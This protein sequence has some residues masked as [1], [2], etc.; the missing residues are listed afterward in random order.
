MS[1]IVF[2]SI[3]AYGHT[4]PT[5]EVVRQLVR[6]GHRVRYYS[7]EEFRAKLEGAGAEFVPC[8]TFLPPAPRDLGRRMGHDF[9]SLMAMVIDVTVAMEEK[10]L[11][12]LGEFRPDCVVADSICVWGKLYAR[13]LGLPLVCSTTTFAFDQETARAMRP[14]P[15]EVFYTLTGLPQI[16]KRLALLREHGYEVEKLTELIQN[17]SETDT[18]VYTSRAF[19]PGGEH[20]GERVAF[21]GPS[22]PELPP[23]TQRRER[24]LV[25]VSLGTVMHGN[26]GFYRACAEGLGDGPWDVLLS[27]GSPEG[28]AA[29]GALPPNVRAEARVEQLRVLGEASVF[30]THCGMNSVS[31]S[32]WCG[33]PMVLAPQQSEEAAV[34]RRAAELGAGLRLERRGPAAIRAAVEEVLAQREAY[35]RAIAPLAA[36]F[37]AAGGAARAAEKIEET[38]A[39]K[40]EEARPQRGAPTAPR[41]FC[42]RSLRMTEI[43]L[44][45]QFLVDNGEHL[46]QLGALL[47]G[48]TLPDALGHGMDV[49]V[50]D[51]VV[52]LVFLGDLEVVLALVVGGLD[53]LHIA[54][55]DQAVDLIGRV[56]RRDAHKGGE[57]VDGWAA[58]GL[59]GLHGE[60]LY[61]GQAGLAVLKAL[62]DL[63]IKMKLEFGIHDFK[64]LFQHAGAPALS[65]F[66]HFIKKRREGQSQIFGQGK[67]KLC[68]NG[69]LAAHGGFGLS[70]SYR[71]LLL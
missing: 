2:F 9:S 29:L 70:D 56:G 57:L 59:D 63:L 17:D 4:N 39:R 64:F 28:A 23:R 11:R 15:L 62:E 66:F 1:R 13:R 35:R 69:Q 46:F 48:E 6:R 61:R 25:Y 26:T 31:E 16:G 36:G 44:G 43:H 67:G 7:F 52:V 34:A 47:R 68:R 65:Y 50:A 10:V 45:H 3:P 32:I 71:A 5:V 49:V 24:P 20:F 37:R 21:V 40:T 18:I 33:V 54:L 22:L 41:L 8:D 42:L 58:Q 38:I 53:L 55:A 60:G 14:G 30:L 27:V 12:E 19:Q 51:I